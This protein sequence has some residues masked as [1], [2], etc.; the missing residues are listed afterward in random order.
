MMLKLKVELT[1]DESDLLRFLIFQSTDFT[2]F[3]TKVFLLWLNGSRI[4]RIKEL[5][6]IN[7]PQGKLYPERSFPNLLKGLVTICYNFGT[8]FV[9]NSLKPFLYDSKNI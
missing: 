2:A 6:K 9:T 1:K 7:V 8:N 5:I 4:K 3:N